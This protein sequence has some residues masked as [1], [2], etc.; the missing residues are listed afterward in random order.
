[1]KIVGDC[2]DQK[3]YWPG[4]RNRIIPFSITKPAREFCRSKR[5][6]GPRYSQP[7]VISSFFNSGT[8]YRGC[9]QN[10]F[11]IA[12]DKLTRADDM[13]TG[14]R[15]MIK[16]SSF[17]LPHV[18][19]HVS[20]G[21]NTSWRNNHSQHQKGQEMKHHSAKKWTSSLTAQ[22]LLLIS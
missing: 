16:R 3:D 8:S 6:I 21:G 10:N 17:V 18:R 5:R 20:V 4:G 2:L 11:R 22:L 9:P 14:S 12:L 7:R 15:R 19:H 1:M 13:R